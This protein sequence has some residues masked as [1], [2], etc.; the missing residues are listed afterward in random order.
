M[1]T[2]CSQAPLWRAVEGRPLMPPFEDCR[3]W[4][5][6]LAEGIGALRLRSPPSSLLHPD[7]PSEDRGVIATGAPSSTPFR[8]TLSLARFPN[9]CT[10]SQV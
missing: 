3:L 9:C 2:I 6:A 5:V 8:P 10:I 1:Q 4:R 7:P